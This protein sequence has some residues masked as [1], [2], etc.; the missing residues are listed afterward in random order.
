[1]QPETNM[2][3]QNIKI[4]VVNSEHKSKDFRECDSIIE[5]HKW[6]ARHRAV[7]H[8]GSDDT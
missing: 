3:L 7:D 2:C 8:I 4:T 1:V 5:L 6:E